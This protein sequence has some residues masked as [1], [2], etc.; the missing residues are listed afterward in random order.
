MRRWI[1]APPVRPSQAL[2]EAV[3]GHP[4]V[5]ETLVR[6]GFGDPAAAAAFLD[7][8]AYRPA[9]PYD[10]PDMD[11]G[12]ER[13]HAAIARGEP[14]LI[15]G[16][17][18][19]DGQTATALLYEAFQALGGH[20]RAYVPQRE[21]EGHG[22][23][24]G[25]L[26]H[27]IA[28]GI[29]LV[30]TCDTGIAEHEALDAARR[31]GVDVVVTDHHNLPEALPAAHALIN[32]KRLPETHPLRTLP[33]VG[34]AYKLVEALA[35]DQRSDLLE[36]S[37]DLVALGIVVD[38]AEQVGDTRW[39]LQRGLARLRQTDRLGLLELY[40]RA[41][42]DAPLLNEETL[43]FRL[44]PRLNAVGRLGD[45]NFAVE[46]LTTRDRERAALLATQF[47]GLNAERKLLTD[48]VYAGALRQIDRDPGLL[49]DAVLVLASPSWPVGVLG[50]VASRLAEEFNRPTVL[51]SGTPGEPARGS[52]RSVPGCDITAALAANADLLLDYGGHTLAAGL[53][54]E[55]E[56]I[57][58]LR[59]ALNR[60]VAAQLAAAGIK[61]ALQID[62][63]VALGDLTL[64]LIDDLE[65][66]APF[67][68]GNPPLTLA[69]RDLSVKSRRAIGRGEEHVR[70]TVADANDGEASLIWWNGGGQPLPEGRFDLAF[71]ARS[72]TFR[73]ERRVQ[74]E[75]VEA[76][77]ASAPV[78]VAE[79][80]P[81]Q[82]IDYR[83]ESDP[84]FRLA[85]LRLEHSDLQVWAEG[86]QRERVDGRTRHE[87]QPASAL[88]IWTTP[89]GTQALRAAVEQVDPDRVFIFA[90]D[91]ELDKEAAFLERLG[92]LLKYALRVHDGWIT[93]EKLAA[94]LAHN[95]ETVRAGLV[96][97]LA[98]GHLTLLAEQDGA[99]RLGRAHEA[100]AASP[101][102]AASV[103]ATLRALLLETAAYR[104][105][106]CAGS[107]S[108]YAHD[109]IAVR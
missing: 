72:N 63:W 81:R 69:A 34:C 12:G 78:T 45:A 96:W 36:R 19:V 16:D 10:L 99:L 49:D 18:D 77:A 47:E 15:W 95:S 46:L 17:F 91:P 90:I 58:A 59:R 98:A 55:P 20:V 80:P 54:V 108:S 5:A 3:G 37:L 64:D 79:R 75:W 14:I 109:V 42:I 27:F 60:T 31:S 30:V 26:A 4:L 76:R 105:L 100:H 43:G 50:L 85:A 41:E 92:G 74:L 102:D 61:P 40:K 22:I 84:V 11:R 73:G 6:R 8:S 24:G 94:A 2:R 32:P 67:G 97:L 51:I 53:S 89:P 21:T 1:D 68:A 104:R 56:Q 7:P 28:E 82:L 29:R 87:L 9:S 65:R 38:V 66:L 52:A 70:I 48:Q 71:T 57:A 86:P 39:L 103:R 88:A 83:H 13:I 106:F 101:A 23:A 44:G 35:A 25:R 107:L 62:G 33:G 93:Y